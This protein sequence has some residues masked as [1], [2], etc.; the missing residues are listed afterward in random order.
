[1]IMITVEEGLEMLETLDM[2]GRQVESKLACG[3]KGRC[4][5][6]PPLVFLG[7]EEHSGLA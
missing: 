1:M 3:P 6:W 5:S 7:P 4:L 2:D